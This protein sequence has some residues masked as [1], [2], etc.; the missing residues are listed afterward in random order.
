M[1]FHVF[2]CCLSIFFS[3]MSFPLFCLYSN[4][5]VFLLF[6]AVS[7]LYFLDTSPLINSLPV[8]SFSV[9]LFLSAS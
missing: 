2:F 7:S 3:T 4:W 6:S 8:F 5:I 1:S 9:C